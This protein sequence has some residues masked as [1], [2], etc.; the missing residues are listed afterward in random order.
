[1]DGTP[2]SPRQQLVSAHAGSFVWADSQSQEFR[3]TGT[4]Q[5]LIRAGGGVGIGVTNLVAALRVRGG[6]LGGL[7]IADTTR[8]ISAPVAENLQIGH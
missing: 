3:T 7:H 5:F 6:S 1:M 2:L 8:D 4:N